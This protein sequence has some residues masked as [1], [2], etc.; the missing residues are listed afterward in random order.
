MTDE[1]SAALARL[2]SGIDG[3]DIILGGGF[4]KGGLYIIQ[5]FPGTGKTTF[6][7]Q[8]CFNHAAGGGRAV[9]VTLLAEYHARMM[10][11]TFFDAS[12]IPTE[13]LTSMVW[14]HCMN[15]GSKGW[16]LFYAVRS[17]RG[18]PLC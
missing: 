7:N 5:G 10:Q 9:Y 14:R 15:P 6:G 17:P 4:L 1:T 8:V 18:A 16:G 2:P 12:K 3:L 13:S 11:M